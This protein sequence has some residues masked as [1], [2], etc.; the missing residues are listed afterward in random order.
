MGNRV[1]FNELAPNTGCIYQA[2]P[3]RSIGFILC[4]VEI[5]RVHVD[6]ATE[7]YAL[8]LKHA[9]SRS[10]VAYELIKEL[11]VWLDQATHT[12]NGC[13]SSDEVKPIMDR[14]SA[15]LDAV[16]G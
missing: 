1:A 14:A 5:L 12:G 7:P 2:D 11:Q 3:S 4:G 10:L 9:I 8:K 15:Y 6:S 13:T 16:E